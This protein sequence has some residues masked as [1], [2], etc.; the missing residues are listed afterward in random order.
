MA[1]GIAADSDGAA[2]GTDE[3]CVLVAGVK[4]GRSRSLRADGAS[5]CDG[6]CVRLRVGG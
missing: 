5:V 3:E 4:A 6:G 1:E 2:G